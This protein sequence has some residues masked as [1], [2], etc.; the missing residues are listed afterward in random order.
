MSNTNSERVAREALDAM[1]ALSYQRDSGA[2]IVMPNLYQGGIHDPAVRRAVNVAGM[3]KRHLFNI[4]RRVDSAELV[5][6]IGRHRLLPKDVVRGMLELH[7]EA[8]YDHE[9]V[10]DP[11]R[12]KAAAANVR[13]FGQALHITQ[14]QQ[15]RGFP[16]HELYRKYMA[17]AFSRV[18]RHPQR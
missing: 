1:D 2:R 14:P 16:F 3:E 5:N 18:W 4:S 8:L 12:V 15:F 10:I 7:D 6:W 9:A 17:P 11:E 13:R